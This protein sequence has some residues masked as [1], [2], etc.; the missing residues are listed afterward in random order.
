MTPKVNL[1]NHSA[2][3]NGEIE[4]VGDVE[5]VVVTILDEDNQVVGT[6]SGKTLAIELNSVHLWQ[7]GKAYLYRAKVELYQAG[8]VIDTYIEAFGIRQIDRKSVV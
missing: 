3:V 8:Q 2:V 1:T 4:T 6:T 7:P 5:Q